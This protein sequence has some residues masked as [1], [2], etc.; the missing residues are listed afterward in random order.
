MLV[1][2]PF[3][4]HLSKEVAKRLAKESCIFREQDRVA[5]EFEDLV[6]DELSLEDE[7]NAEARALLGQ[8]GEYMRH[9]NISYHEMFSTVKRK[10]L[11]ER[12]ILSASPDG[13]GPRTMKLS[14][15]KVREMSHKLASKLPRI[16][17][18]RLNK[19]WNDTRLEIE[20]HL[21]DIFTMEMRCD[22][23]A[24]EKIATQ[25]RDIPEGSEEW[26]ALHRNY[27]EDELKKHGVFLRREYAAPRE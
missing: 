8:Y 11:A 16:P 26:Q 6:L 4:T 20:R 10:L 24:K 1:P 15:D 2:P 17:G 23:V 5:R 18:T 25:K 21:K 22:R 27:Y 19:T 12:R 14:H 9:Q 3:I 13:R 7:V